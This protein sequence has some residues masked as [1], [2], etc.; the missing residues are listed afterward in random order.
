ME[1]KTI[2]G[3]KC[4]LNPFNKLLFTN[5]KRR[6]FMTIKT[7]KSSNF[8]FYGTSS[9]LK[10]FL[11]K[12]NMELKEIFFSL[13]ERFFFFFLQRTIHFFFKKIQNVGLI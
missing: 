12:I 3:H 9:F 7:P 8:C 5:C 4:I 2:F 13:F 10:G 6:W 11:V 1:G